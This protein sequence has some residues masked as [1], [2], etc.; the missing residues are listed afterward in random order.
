MLPLINH[1]RLSPMTMSMQTRFCFL[2]LS[3]IVP[4]TASVVADEPVVAP[5]DI[6][7]S[8]PGW[9]P[10][11]EKDLVNVNG[12]PD[13]W[14]WK[15]DGT[16]H[17]TGNPVGVIRSQKQYKNFELV[18][19]WCHRRDAGNSGI[20]IWTTE[21]SLGR[22]KPG[23]LP[24]GIEVQ[25]L[26]HGY[27]AQ[28]EKSTSK[29][30]DWFTS[31]G[32]V[33]PVGVRMT[34]YPPVAPDGQRSFPTKHVSKGVNEWNHYFIRANKGEVR[35]WVNGEMVSG[36]KDCDPSSG[37]LCFESEGSPIDFREIKIRELPE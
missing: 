32:D 33:F 5:A 16:L 4:I 19:E 12:N 30:A 35:L 7:A 20:F 13:T 10:I 14:T 8:E 25:I 31:H 37:F 23:Q 22:I 1:L 26:D 21:A 17:C 28:Y 9:V 3:T 27:T 2:V 29:K 24:Q 18:L 11:T 34:P 15:A 36:G 6:K